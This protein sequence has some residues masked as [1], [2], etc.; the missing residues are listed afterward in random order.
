MTDNSIL[1]SPTEEFMYRTIAIILQPSLFF[2]RVWQAFPIGSFKLRLAFDV[3]QKPHY[4][5]GI[6]HA[7]HTALKLG[8]GRISAI[9][10]GVWTGRG[11][12]EMER[13][14]REITQKTGVEIEIY[15]FD[16]GFG[17]PT[18]G[19]YRDLPHVWRGGYYKLNEEALRSRLTSAS[20]VIGDVKDTIPEFFCKYNPAP[21]GF[22]AF[23]L[24][25]YTS[26]VAALK[27][28]DYNAERFL[29]RVYSY[30]DDIIFTNR[31]VGEILAIDEFNEVHP[32][33]KIAHLH[34][35]ETTRFFRQ[36]WN[37]GMHITHFFNHPSYEDL[38]GFFD[39][40]GL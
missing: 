22:A 1:R 2:R 9:E 25:Y 37:W 20:L 15:G 36:R 19:D 7:A 35:I 38:V 26:T 12:L 24:D 28:F 21:V 31:Y 4:A 17:L 5:Y 11:L 8:I 30:F 13:I 40:S 14:A 34:G 27:I 29:P 10:F 16:T 23:D 18:H 33:T 39:H 6:F 3:F 32:A